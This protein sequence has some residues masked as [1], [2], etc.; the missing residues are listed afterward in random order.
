MPDFISPAGTFL[1]VLSFVA[2]FLVA[3][4]LGRKRRER[5]RER[6]AAAH[7]AGQSRQVR[8]AS[9]RKARGR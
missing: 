3:R 4:M 9:Q 2:T 5:K 8:R 1:A 6:E 7:L